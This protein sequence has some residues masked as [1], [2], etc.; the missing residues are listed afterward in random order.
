MR[1]QNPMFDARVRE[2]VG[3]TLHQMQHKPVVQGGNGRGP[4][5]P[6]QMLAQALGWD[7]LEYVICPGSKMIAQGYAHHYKIDIANPELKIA[8]EVDGN[9]H[10]TLERQ[11]EDIKKEVLLR[12]LG[13]IVLRFTNGQIEKD[14]KRCVQMVTFT[15]S[16]LKNT[17]PI[18]QMV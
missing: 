9:S 13:W 6:Q 3:K 1:T 10:C 7:K 5:R 17:I 11:M 18:S 8:I 4:T 2:K 14:L 15:I 16:K 12:S